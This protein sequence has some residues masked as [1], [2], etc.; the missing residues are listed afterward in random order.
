MPLWKNLRGRIDFANPRIY[1]RTASV[2]VE[3]AIG[4]LP[5]LKIGS[6][7]RN[8]ECVDNPLYETKI[9]SNIQAS[10][11]LTPAIYASTRFTE[12]GG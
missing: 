12:E 4:M 3:V 7:W 6:I 8:G 11:L 10:S 5:Y 2:S 1:E 9:F